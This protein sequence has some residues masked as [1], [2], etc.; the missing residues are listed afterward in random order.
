MILYSGY[1]TLCFTV[2]CEDEAVS[3]VLFGCLNMHVTRR[4]YCRKHYGQTIYRWENEKPYWKCPIC[5]HQYVAMEKS[6]IYETML[7]VRTRRRPDPH[8][9][10][11][12]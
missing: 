2:D 5:K 12:R 4:D 6:E 1:L 3:V 10:L 11:P 7:L 8:L 9:G